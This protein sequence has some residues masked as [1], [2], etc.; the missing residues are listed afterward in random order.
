[1]P[2]WYQIGQTLT[3]ILVGVSLFITAINGLSAGEVEG[4]IIGG[5]P[6]FTSLSLDFNV[7]ETNFNDIREEI[8]PVNIS[9]VSV[10]L[11]PF[12]FLSILVTTGIIVAKLAF[13][14]LTGW[15]EVL[16][17]I[18]GPLGLCCNIDTIGFVIIG[19][20]GAIQLY[21]LFKF[22]TILASVIRGGGG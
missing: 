2:D 22:V 18:L 4:G 3:I 8:Q 5:N 7:L 6:T 12:Q 20:L 17:A 1:M 19:I 9:L 15:T 11:I 16:L 10:V 21:F 13:V 14:L